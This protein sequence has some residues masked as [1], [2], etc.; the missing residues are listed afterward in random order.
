MKVTL[1][2]LYTL[3]ADADRVYNTGNMFYT[4]GVT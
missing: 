3:D 4:A 1:D 2:T